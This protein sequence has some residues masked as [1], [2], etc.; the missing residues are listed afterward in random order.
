MFF[1]TILL[2]I[3]EP[4]IKFGR[5]Q[6]TIDY[7]IAPLITLL[8]L[9]VL[10][11]INLSTII[12]ALGGNSSI[13]PW[14]IIIIFFA[15][16]YVFIS[17]DTTGI[18][19]YLSFKILKLTH[20]DGHKL[21]F[22]LAGFA[23]IL[24]MFTS[25]DI[26]TLTMTPIVLYLGK[27]SK[28]NP[29]PY[30]MIVFFT[31]NTWS[32]IFY[33][34]SPTNI[35][36]AQALELGF[37]EYTKFMI[38]PTLVAGV[39]TTILAFIMFNKEIPKHVSVPRRINP[40]DY[41]INKTTAKIGL[42]LVFILFLTL[43]FSESLP[44]K[45]WEIIGFFALVFITIN[46]FISYYHL[47]ISHNSKKYHDE[48]TKSITHT[49][50]LFSRTNNFFMVIHRMPWKILPLIISFFILT[51]V[52]ALNG[53]DDAIAI[54]I[55]NFRGIFQGTIFTGIITAISANIMIDQPMTMLFATSMQSPHYLITDTEKLSNA[56]AL[57]IGANLGDN[58]TL[59]GALAGIMWC[60]IL[61]FNGVEMN[62]LKFLSY[63][64]R[65]IP[66]VI[67][68]TCIVLALQMNYLA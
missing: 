10:G 12:E 48:K 45:I 26:V 30:L 54:G 58:L 35:I 62:Y 33:I 7:G 15:A 56:F 20:N 25:N 22:Y 40:Q 16:A 37:F 36:V 4:I 13:I 57:V 14:Q 42:V 59:F 23:A 49:N 38:I 29:L 47:E 61:K 64:I 18:F 43:I 8:V 39:L 11:Y 34:G 2:I 67:I 63:S 28:I 55:S 66:M 9:I 27:H 32:M 6:I 17:L 53:I 19:E 31:A 41:L 60:K 51:H 24:T 44:Y 50:I 21:F 68:I 65:V 46:L 52:L 3:K 5:R 1:F